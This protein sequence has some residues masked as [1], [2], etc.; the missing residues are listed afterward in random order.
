MTVF[1]VGD[2]TA[3]ASND[4]ASENVS[5]V[6]A[7]TATS[8]GKILYSVG[9]MSG[10]GPGVGAQTARMMAYAATA[11]SAGPG[12]RAGY[13][14]DVTIADGAAYANLR[15]DWA[16]AASAQV[17]KGPVYVGYNASAVNNGSQYAYTATGALY[18]KNADIT[19]PDDPFGTPSGGPLAIQYSA[20]LVCDDGL[21]AMAMMGMG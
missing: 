7:A 15:F 16:V 4:N 6:S 11:F 19:P 9:R 2:K 18:Y 21:S 17:T 1:L 14:S 3:G 10:N 5:V 12:T 13:S 8:T 20:Y